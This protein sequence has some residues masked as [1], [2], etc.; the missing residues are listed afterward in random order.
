MDLNE[1]RR[2]IRVLR[3]HNWGRAA[4]GGVF[5]LSLLLFGAAFQSAQAV[6]KALASAKDMV[7]IGDAKCTECHDESEKY[8]VLAIGKTRHGTKADA[9]TPTCTSCHGESATHVKLPQGVAAKDRP[10][11]ERFGRNKNGTIEERNQNCLDC[12]QG[13]AR[14]MWGGSTH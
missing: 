9:R 2:G 4:I 14:M 12:H 6:D 7:L 8:P 1:R 5:S 13:G 10:K 11:P 3:S